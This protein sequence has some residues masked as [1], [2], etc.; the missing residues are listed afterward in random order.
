MTEKELRK[1]IRKEVRE[2]LAEENII[3]K[4]LGKILDGMSVASQKRALKKLKKRGF[5]QDLQQAAAESDAV[6]RNLD[7]LNRL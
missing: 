1:K 3:T 5:Y 7:I 6:K 2:T 4:V